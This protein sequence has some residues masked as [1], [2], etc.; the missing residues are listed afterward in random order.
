M[1][2]PQPLSVYHRDLNLAES[3]NTFTIDY[4]DIPRIQRQRHLDDIGVWIGFR[5][6]QHYSYCAQNSAVCH[7]ERTFSRQH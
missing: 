1:S 3:G 2:K 7:Q 6:D 4:I 5:H